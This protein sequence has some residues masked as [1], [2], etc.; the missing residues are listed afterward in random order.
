MNLAALAPA[1]THP[2]HTCASHLRLLGCSRRLGML[3]LISSFFQ[4]AKRKSFHKPPPT[5]PSKYDQAPHPSN[6]FSLTQKMIF[7]NCP[8][9]ASWEKDH[10]YLL[11]TLRVI[12]K[13]HSTA[14]LCFV[15]GC[16]ELAFL[17]S[18]PSPVAPVV[19][20]GG[21]LMRG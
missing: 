15:L 21:G 4:K 11:Q 5:S 2:D 17:G 13:R 9:L 1:L 18:L 16:L 3:Y 14:W 7:R 20:V 19:P 10:E 12:E 6:F 8:S